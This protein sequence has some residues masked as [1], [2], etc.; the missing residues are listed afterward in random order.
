MEECPICMEEFE[1][2]C[3]CVRCKSNV[4][5]KCIEQIRD[6]NI[7]FIK[8]I[9][10][11][12]CRLV[13]VSLFE[14]IKHSTIYHSMGIN[15]DDIIKYYTKEEII[16]KRAT[17]D[18]K[19]TLIIR[20]VYFDRFDIT[21]K[22]LELGCNPSDVNAFGKDAF[23]YCKNSTM[24]NLLTSYGNRNKISVDTINQILQLGNKNIGELRRMCADKG[25][26]DELFMK[27]TKKRD[28]ITLLIN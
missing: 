27:I 9:K 23:Y 10:C 5:N 21:M 12:F 20:A 25:I 3:I 16:N 28:L 13:N 6:S 2:S 26:N 11:P 18:D 1:L 19:D 14:Y 15:F 4:C 24:F 8:S 22:L 7:C 17:T